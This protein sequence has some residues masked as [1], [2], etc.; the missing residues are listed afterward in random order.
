M[1]P[2]HAR[3]Q[4]EQKGAAM[5]KAGED[6]VGPIAS[7][8]RCR[9]AIAVLL[10]TNAAAAFAAVPTVS[11][12]A[13]DNL[14]TEAGPTTATLT[15]S[16]VGDI[17]KSLTVS[18]AVSGTA[19]SG[20]D[21]TSIGTSVSIPAGAASVT[22]TVTA[23]QDTLQEQDETIVA[24]IKTSASYVVGTP[25]AATVTLT[26]DD[27]ITQTVTVAATDSVATEAGPTTG[28]YTFTRTG[29]I[30]AALTV[31]YKVS[32]TATSITDFA[33]LG[34]SVKFAAGAA[35]VTKALTPLFD[36]LEEGAETAVVTLKQSASYLPGAASS[37]SVSITNLALQKVAV[38]A[39]ATDP[40][41]SPLHYEWRSTDGR[42]DNIDS[43]T[44][45]WTLPPGRGI[46]FA[47]V[48]V[49]NGK[50]GYTER[51][52]AVITD[53]IGLPS[54]QLPSGTYSPPAA[55]ASTTNP[56]VS[57]VY[58]GYG[59]GSLLYRAFKPDALVYAL[60]MN[61]QQTFPPTGFYSSDLRGRFVIPG[62][63]TSAP[64]D[65][66]V[67]YCSPDNG[68]NWQGCANEPMADMANS[69][70]V[71]EELS[72]VPSYIGR[73]RLADGSVCGAINEFFDKEQTATAVVRS[74]SGLEI[75]TVAR[76]SADGDF[77]LPQKTKGAFVRVT[78]EGA[79]PVDITVAGVTPSPYGNIDVGLTQRTGLAGPVIASMTATLGSSQVGLFLPP[80]T[81]VPSDAVPDAERF[82]T[83]QG[84][85]SR[86]GACQYYKAIGA[87][88]GC[89]A[90]G[91]FISPINVEDWKRTVKIGAYATAGTPEFSATFINQVDLNLTRNHHSISYGP[92]KTAAYVCNH[93]GPPSLNATQAEIDTAI[94]NA[95]AGKNLVACVMMDHNAKSSVNGGKPFTRFLIFGPSGEL[96]PSINLDG[97]REKFVPGICVACH[98]GSKYAGFYPTDGTGPAEIGA[99]FLPYDIGNFAF[100][101][102]TGLRR[103]DQE[104]AI[105][106]LNQNVLK[107]GPTPAALELIAGWYP[108]TSKVQDLNYLPISWVGKGYDQAYHKIFAHSCRTCHV[109]LDERF[110]FDHYDNTQFSRLSTSVCAGFSGTHDNQIR[111]Y[112]MPNSLVTFNRFWQTKGTADDLT[113]LF[114]NF[115]NSF[116]N[117]ATVPPCSLPPH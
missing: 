66:Y 36:Y 22:K 27:A 41:G 29:N 46:H 110:N 68:I 102:K 18:Y 104:L 45:N 67:I 24:T 69:D 83:Y 13:S 79:P 103:V 75:S 5:T 94:D 53:T 114:A 64:D 10:L 109:N 48:L 96:L 31:S 81:G 61:T 115:M 44:T 21:F 78:C 4:Q 7:V 99:H 63:P 97:R 35:T 56:F 72:V 50:G 26:S 51:R 54:V 117:Q 92:G 86:V 52:V 34:T 95:V 28:T 91:A 11:V 106:N 89:G 112:S 1:R 70:Y 87:V 113:D 101:S 108:G 90:G 80:P 40:N 42:I 39:V 9:L 82:F 57:H 20:S 19:T 37:A 111:R 6:H 74:V 25:S 77:A 93:L 84:I 107:A 65:F 15:F 33:T 3:F 76:L 71:S 88:K 59:E 105:Y 58:W 23:L 98:G 49:S 2:R 12:V 8:L 32:G 73:F 60:D 30:S 62:L 85:D 47:Y 38:N 116:F 100:S 17:T 14:A 55:S 43:P 16:R